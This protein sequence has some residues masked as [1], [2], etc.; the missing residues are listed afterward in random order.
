MP[1]QQFPFVALDP[2][3]KPDPATRKL[4]RKHAIRNVAN[5]RRESKTFGKRNLLQYP[6]CDVLQAQI[7]PKNRDECGIAIENRESA[8]SDFTREQWTQETEKHVQEPHENTIIS[9]ARPFSE[10]NQSLTIERLGAGRH[11]PF[12]T[13]P[14]QITSQRQQI[15]DSA[16]VF[17]PSISTLKPY[18]DSYYII[19]RDDASAFHQFLA[20]AALHRTL[21]MSGGKCLRSY[22]ATALH[23]K[24]LQLAQRRIGDAKEEVSDGMIATVLMMAAYNH[25]TLDLKAW[26]MHMDGI[27]QILKLRGGIE[28]LN[29]NI[30]LRLLISWHSISGSC[31]FDLIPRFPLP[32]THATKPPLPD[33]TSYLSSP[34]TQSFHNTRQ[35]YYT[36]HPEIS[37]LMDDLHNFTSLLKAETNWSSGRVWVENLASGF[38]INHIVQQSLHLQTIINPDDLKSIMR[39]ASRLGVLL[40]LAEIRRDFGVYPVV[41]HIHISKLRSLL[42]DSEDVPWHEFKPLK[43]WV[44]VMALLEAK[45]SEDKDW[46]ADQIRGLT[47]ELNLKSGEE[48]EELLE[49]MFWYPQIHSKLLWSNIRALD[50]FDSVSAERI[51][52]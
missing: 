17:D 2:R 36:D 34:S 46:F 37:H 29:S 24:A 20:N 49:G 14:I 6:P 51:L 7:R 12:S 26:K 5:A 43:L 15:L 28:T 25:I 39:E 44:L 11:D 3:T 48:L 9:A 45:S 23:Y 30:R 27:E 33:L 47:E 4:I 42:E 40:Y 35:T 8:T 22:E 10:Y 52:Q 19:A 50:M 21:Y 38:W 32:T 1:V 18:R 41:T 16:P 31:S 13:Y